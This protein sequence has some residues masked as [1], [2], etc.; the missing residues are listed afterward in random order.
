VSTEKIKNMYSDEV[1]LALLEQSINNINTTLIRFEKRFDQLDERYNQM[2]SS[3]KV[4][5]RWLFSI[6]IGGFAG[7]FAI[8]AHGFHWY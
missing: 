7:M 1:R 2:E 5:I 3:I 6:M 8:M 4:D